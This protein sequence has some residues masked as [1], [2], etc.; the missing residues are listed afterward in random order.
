MPYSSAMERCSDIY[1]L[2][3]EISAKAPNCQPRMESAQL[4]TQREMEGSQTANSW[5]PAKR[6]STIK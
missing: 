6:K 2:R 3:S 5:A 1:L 4:Y